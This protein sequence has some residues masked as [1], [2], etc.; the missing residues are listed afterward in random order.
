MPNNMRYAKIILIIFLLLAFDVNISS[1]SESSGTIDSIYKSTKI[2]KNTSCSEYGN[3]NLKPTSGTAVS[4]VD[5][6][7]LSG[8][9]WGDE[10]GWVNL[11]PTGYGVDISTSTGALSGYAYSQT[12]SWINFNPTDVSGGTDVGVTINSSGQFVGWAWVS[13]AHGGWMKFD[14]A[15]ASTCIKTDWRPF[16]SRSSVAEEDTPSDTGGGSSG[17]RPSSESST[18]TVSQDSPVEDNLPKY[19]IQE[20]NKTTV[21]EEPSKSLVTLLADQEVS[22]VNADVCSFN[23]PLIL[24]AEQSGILVY[25][26]DR[27]AG[28]VVEV[29]KN[30][31]PVQDS[32]SID[33]KSYLLA[34]SDKLFNEGISI[35]GETIFDIRAFDKSNNE[36][37]SFP[38]PIKITLIV[39]DYLKG[40][41]DIG[42]Y[43]LN[44]KRNE[45]IKV[46]HVVFLDSSA[47]FYVDHLTKFA[48][49]KYPDSPEIIDA[50]ELS[51]SYSLDK[52]DSF[53]DRNK[54]LFYILYAII[55]IIIVIIF[56]I[57]KQKKY[58]HEN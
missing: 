9:I 12:G 1:A 44:E 15:S 42:V 55:F 11:S 36:I 25:E 3:I 2:C 45:W 56:I 26:F 4:I 38:K 58:R 30:S 39:P 24:D 28:S 54:M 20:E 53:Y 6:T 32:L 19:M 23:K 34:R 52:E 43:W 21:F 14:C 31:N 17:S 8:Y 22:C 5:G 57:P 33:I 18:T 37:H 35:I 48:I 41:S 50:G 16:A 46:P 13:G 49:I 47:V 51:R 7:G 29:N 10:I 27:G 40:D